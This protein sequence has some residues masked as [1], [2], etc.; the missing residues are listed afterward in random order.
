[1][2]K[3]IV[4]FCRCRPQDSDAI[5]IVLEA[6]RAFIGYPAWRKGKYEQE[7]S[8]RSAIV[9]LS[10]VGQDK[11]ALDRRIR[12]WRRQIS[13]NRN[14]VRD[15]SDGSILLVPRPGR[16]FVYAGRTVGFEL[17]DTP[18]WGSAYLSLRRKQGLVD[19]PC[20]AHLADVVQGW[21]VDH[22]RPVPFPAIPAWIRASLLG[23]STVGRISPIHLLDLELDPFI[24]LDRIIEHPETIF[25]SNTSDH[26]EIER[27]LVTDIGPSAFEHLIVA[28]LQLERPEEVWR[29]VGGSGDGGV[30]GLG[31]NRTGNVVGLLQC[32][33]RHDGGEL[34]F[35]NESQIGRAHV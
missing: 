3:P 30:D 13:L 23:R 15:V 2:S 16:G 27:R 32:K 12:E 8:F 35:E 29:H 11:N 33:W 22:W 31:A 34:A 6:K 28:L 1:M 19:S 18:P 7:D 4:F 5:D 20:G 24:E 9:D 10:E 17:V 25:R 21:R 26:K 14:L